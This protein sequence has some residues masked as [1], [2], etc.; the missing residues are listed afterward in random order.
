MWS[1]G[2]DEARALLRGVVAVVG[3]RR[4]VHSANSDNNDNNDNNSDDALWRCVDV[5][6]ATLRD[7][8]VRLALHAGFASTFERVAR[9][10]SSWRVRFADGNAARHAATLDIVDDDDDDE[11]GADRVGGVLCSNKRAR[12][13]CCEMPSGYVSASVSASFNTQT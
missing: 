1:L 10:C 11:R 8:L 2:R 12:V 3:Y 13:W 7:E 9:Q 6:D 4:A 5:C